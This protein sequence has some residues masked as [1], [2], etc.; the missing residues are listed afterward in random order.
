MNIDVIEQAYER[1]VVAV[2]NAIPDCGEDD[3]EELVEAVVELVLITIM[4][5]LGEHNVSFDRH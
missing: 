2:L 4:F 1:A 3:A 5:K